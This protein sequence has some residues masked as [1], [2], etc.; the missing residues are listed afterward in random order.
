MKI[1]LMGD[2]SNFHRTLATGLRRL[3]CDVTVASAGSDFMK[4]ERDIDLRRPFK[5]KAGGLALW[6][7]LNG[8]LGKRLK[9]FDIVSVSNCIFVEQKPSRIKTLFNRLKRDNGK[10]FLTALGTD[11][12][13]LEECLDPYSKLKYNEYRIGD[14]EAPYARQHTEIITDWQSAPLRDWCNEFYENIDGAVS[15]LYEYHIALSRRLSPSRIAYGGIP[16][17]LSTL[18]PVEIPINPSPIKIF[19][20]RHRHRLSEK[21]TDRFE[22]AIKKAL[23]KNPGK[24]ELIIVENRPYEEYITLMRNSHVIVDQAYS[25]T[26]ATN[27]LLSMGYGIPTISGGENDFYDFIENQKETNRN[28]QSSALDFDTLNETFKM[29]YPKNADGSGCKTIDF[30]PNQPIINSPT[31]VEGMT[32]MFNYILNHPE[33]LRPIGRASRRFVATNNDCEIVAKRFLDFWASAN[34]R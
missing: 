4:T 19:L 33:I 25:Y 18:S 17:D 22:I 1:L 29:P 5:G 7:R 27:A 6:L 9:G 2:A 3:G 28:K 30:N 20:G 12:P 8:S 13:Y 14:K 23:D 15:A 31:D 32:E 11:L 10:I 24:G 16:I 26:P 21:G 34:S